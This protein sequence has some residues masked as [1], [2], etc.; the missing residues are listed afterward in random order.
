M[1]PCT[2]GLLCYPPHPGIVARSVT[3]RAACTRVKCA[4]NWSRA[5]LL[6]ERDTPAAS[7][8][9]DSTFAMT[10]NATPPSAAPPPPTART[11]PTLV[12]GGNDKDAVD[13]YKL[14]K[15]SP[16]VDS[17]HFLDFEKTGDHV[18]VE[19]SALL[20]AILGPTWPSPSNATTGSH[21]LT[22]LHG[23]H[24]LE[25][26]LKTL[27]VKRILNELDASGVFSTVFKTTSDWE[28]AIPPPAQGFFLLVPCSV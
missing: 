28:E 19:R 4:L 1:H 16:L 7:P 22:M 2:P 27:T 23:L 5:P 8:S 25:Y 12:V 20:G 26:E 6:V 9:I 3:E 11:T 15:D 21:E 14:P 24:F 10:D 18:R 17:F 13:F